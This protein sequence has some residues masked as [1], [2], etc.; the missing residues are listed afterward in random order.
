MRKI[1]VVSI[2]GSKSSGKT[3]TIEVLT[4]ELTKK[5]YKIAAVKHIPEL[6]FTID[7][8]DKDTWRFAKSGAK[9]ILSVAANEIATI[10]KVDTQDFSLQK[11]LQKCKNNDI[12]FLEG[13]RKLVSR[14]RSIHKIVAVKSKEEVSEAIRKFRPL[15]AFTGP[16]SAKE[17][18]AKIPYVDVLKNPEKIAEIVEKAVLYS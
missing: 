10:E 12:V 3:T 4:R 18:D 15:L 17:M 7:T 5:G 9:T 14:N 1:A 6:D 2:V 13:F 16:Y 11:I 8:V